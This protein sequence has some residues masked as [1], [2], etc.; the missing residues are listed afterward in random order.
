ML[1]VT[2]LNIISDFSF[3]AA[4]FQHR[5]YLFRCKNSTLYLGLQLV[6]AETTKKKKGNGSKKNYY[7]LNFFGAK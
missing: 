2:D 1:L 5:F 7:K 4:R 6:F 3:P